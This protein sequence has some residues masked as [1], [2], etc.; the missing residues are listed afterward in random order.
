MVHQSDFL[1]MVIKIWFYTFSLKKLQRKICDETTMVVWPPLKDRRHIPIILALFLL[2]AKDLKEGHI[3]ERHSL[4]DRKV[5]D[6]V[7]HEHHIPDVGVIVL[8]III[9]YIERGIDKSV[10]WYCYWWDVG[11]EAVSND[12]EV[13]IDWTEDARNGGYTIVGALDWFLMRLKRST[14]FNLITK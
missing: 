5:A 2:F 8:F 3:I 14:F 11:G 12:V 7:I 1:R 4:I 6:F 13:P 10:K 9:F